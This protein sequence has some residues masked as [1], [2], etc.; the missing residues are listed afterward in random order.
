MS[1]YNLTA[2]QITGK[3]QGHLIEC[4]HRQLQ[5]KTMQAFI[6]L[7]KAA[8]QA[9]FEARIASGFRDFNRQVWIW[10]NKFN[11]IRPIL[12]IKS[13]PLD[14]NNLSELEK[15]HAIL[16][17]SAIPGGSR[18]HWGSDLDIYCVKSLPKGTALLLEPWEYEENGHQYAFAQWL[19]DNMSQW[20][21]HLPFLVDNGG[22]G[23]EPWHL[24]H[25]PSAALAQ[26][27]FNCN[28]LQQ[29]IEDSD[30]AGKSILLENLPEIY[31]TYFSE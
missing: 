18:H 24:S 31:H 2:Q 4:Q 14:I 3:H 8:K 29:A 28:V 15:I 9:G 13:Q 10:N 16:K 30:M 5:P 20:G 7:Q 17:W 23:I 26:E 12:D 19:N 22:I 27:I 6:A 25:Q 11:G 1:E 21:F